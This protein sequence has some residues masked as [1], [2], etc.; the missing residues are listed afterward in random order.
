MIFDALGELNWLAVIVATVA[1]FI[2]SAIWYS[3][4]PISKPWQRAVKIDPQQS[5]TPLPTIL[6]AT[7][8]LYFITTV[9][10][11]L[12]VEATG[13][14]DAMDGIALGVALGV[15]FGAVSSLIGQ[16]YEQKGSAYWVIN[17]VN[18]IVAWSIVAVILALW[19]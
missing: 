19:D 5:G 1:W 7:V 2:W 15:G 16:L 14:Q 9:V 4:P 12:L 10:I 8:V 11:A 13:A 17:G 3:V 6:A 18:A